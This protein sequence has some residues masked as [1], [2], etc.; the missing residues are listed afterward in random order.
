MKTTW[1]YCFWF[2]Y[3]HDQ[4][5][6]RNHQI[7]GSRA[8]TRSRQSQTCVKYRGTIICFREIQMWTQ[9]IWKYFTK[10]SPNKVDFPEFI[11]NF[12]K[13]LWGLPWT[14]CLTGELWPLQFIWH[15]DLRVTHCQSSAMIFVF[16]QYSFCKSFRHCLLSVW[17]KHFY[18]VRGCSTNT[19]LINLVSQ[20]VSQ[21]IPLNLQKI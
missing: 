11:F 6:K 5:P 8:K 18:T 2:F 7:A 20:S 15:H 1:R 14:Y 12:S 4:K 9:L 3:S 16:T 21:P 17:F 10:K 13:I 19:F